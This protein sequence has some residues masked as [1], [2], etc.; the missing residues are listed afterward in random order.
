MRF[1]RKLP[2]EFDPF[3]SNVMRVLP[4]LV[5]LVTVRPRYSRHCEFA[6]GSCILVMEAVHTM[7]LIY[8][9][10]NR[11][12]AVLL[13]RTENQLRVAVQGADDPLELT[14]V[15]G[16]WISEECE[17]VC[18]EFA[19]EG[20]THQQILTEADCICPQELAARLIHLLWSGDDGPIHAE[21]PLDTINLFDRPAASRGN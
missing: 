6:A 18:V 2:G 15:H 8:A 5:W 12:E 16:T 10:G 14:N 11:K 4:G 9:N 21:A 20:K 7:T 3:V 17:P 13:S 1:G 19:W